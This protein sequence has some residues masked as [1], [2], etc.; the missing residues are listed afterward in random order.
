M[1][2]C[3]AML[4]PLAAFFLLA[5]VR[6]GFDAI[7]MISFCVALIGLSVLVLFVP[8]ASVWISTRNSSASGG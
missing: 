6:D 5:A 8:S 7:F 3:G 1:D 4:G 2:A